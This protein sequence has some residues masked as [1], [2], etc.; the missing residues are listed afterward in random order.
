MS[1]RCVGVNT[2]GEDCKGFLVWSDVKALCRYRVKT[3]DENCIGFLVWSD[4]MVSY[5]LRNEA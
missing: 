4:V 3:N 2:N 5:S 1:K